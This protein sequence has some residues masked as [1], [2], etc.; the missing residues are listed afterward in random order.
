MR[1]SEAHE[2]QIIRQTEEIGWYMDDRQHRDFKTGTLWRVRR[3]DPGFPDI[4]LLIKSDKGNI[5]EGV[6][7]ENYE[8]L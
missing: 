2:G 8:P 7:L 3:A 5:A 4:E 6:T 1:A